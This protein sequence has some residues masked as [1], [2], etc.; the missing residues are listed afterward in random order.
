MGWRVVVAVLSWNRGAH[1]QGITE[2]DYDIFL[3]AEDRHVKLR[4]F[5]THGNRA[6]GYYGSAAR[7]KAQNYAMD[8]GRM[9]GQA[10]PHYTRRAP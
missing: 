1:G 7:V 6:D 4:T 9:L 2:T 8:V 5:S 10:K 3:V